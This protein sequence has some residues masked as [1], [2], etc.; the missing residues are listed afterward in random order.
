M[1]RLTSALVVGGQGFF[2]RWLVAELL[3]QGARVTVLDPAGGEAAA[4]VRVVQEDVEA[5]DV[6]SLLAG[7]GVDAVFQLAGTP[8]VP[9]SLAEPL[10]DL[11][12]NAATTLAVL[13]DARRAATT[14]LVAFVS[15]AAVY[16]DARSVPMDEDHPLEPVSPYG[17][18][19][20]AAERYVALYARLH[21]LRTFSVRPFSLYGPGQRKLVVHDMLVRLLAGESP[22]VVRGSPDVTRDFVYVADAARALARLA[23]AAPAAGEA[24]NIASGSGIRLGDLAKAL[25]R[26]AG[27][28]VQVEFTGNVRSGDPLRWEGDP[29]RAAQLGARVKTPLDEG[30][31]RTLEWLRGGG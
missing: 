28:D 1:R 16:G 27:V 23:S 24:Y 11:R 3:A 19:K 31:R 4:G 12:A 29:G 15:S 30:L 22:L 7:D 8:D 13:E 26:A 9:R 2:G 5:A 21:A 10:A 25:V 6:A 20:L 14:P 17:V 18:S